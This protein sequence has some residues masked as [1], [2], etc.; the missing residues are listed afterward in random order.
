MTVILNL[1]NSVYISDMGSTPFGSGRLIK[2]ELLQDMDSITA[3]AFITRMLFE[4]YRKA[5]FLYFPSYTPHIE[6]QISTHILT[7]EIEIRWVASIPNNY[8]FTGFTENN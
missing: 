4:D 3:T 1:P 6:I 5:K 7:R 8:I 2:Q